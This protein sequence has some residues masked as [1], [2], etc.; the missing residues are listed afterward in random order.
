MAALYSTRFY[1]APALNGVATIGTVP[2]GSIWIVRDISF[3][4]Y[5]IGGPYGTYI[6]DSGGGVVFY[7]LM[8]SGS[9][10][11]HWEGRQVLLAGDTLYAT[12]NAPTA[13]MVSGYVLTAP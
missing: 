1:E 13:V 2:V 5:S 10:Y 3:F 6:S 12:T 9:P 4:M 7:E 8:S 11:A